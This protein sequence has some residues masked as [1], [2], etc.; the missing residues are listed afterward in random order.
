MLQACNESRD[1]C[2]RHWA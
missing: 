1:S 2:P